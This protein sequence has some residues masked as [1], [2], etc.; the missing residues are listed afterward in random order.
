MTVLVAAFFTFVLGK[1]IGAQSRK[2]AFGAETVVGGAGFAV[3][4]IAQTG[5]VQ[6]AGERWSARAEE[7]RIGSGEKVEVVGRDGLCLIVRATG[8]GEKA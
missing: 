8:K 1:G 5:L 4:D 3:T 2:V 6:M 7:G